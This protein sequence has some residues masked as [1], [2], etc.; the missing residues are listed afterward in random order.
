MVFF[1]YPRKKNL[2]SIIQGMSWEMSER[3]EETKNFYQNLGSE[4]NGK[5]LFASKL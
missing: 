1:P 2:Q 3:L 5:V 4:I